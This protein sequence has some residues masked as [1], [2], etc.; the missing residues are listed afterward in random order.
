MQHM[1]RR[2]VESMDA[3]VAFVTEFVFMLT[4]RFVVR[5]MSLSRWRGKEPATEEARIYSAAD[6]LFFVRHGRR[7]V[8]EPGL[9]FFGITFFILSAVVSITGFA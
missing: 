8:T 6:S 4:G 3:A 5:P 1:P 2:N 7:V 9:M